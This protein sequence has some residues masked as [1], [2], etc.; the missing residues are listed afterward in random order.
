MKKVD[1]FLRITD[2]L[3]NEFFP[4]KTV[5]S[6]DKDKPFITQEIKSLIIKRDR[7]L[8]RSVNG[9]FRCY[10]SLVVNEIRKAKLSFYD[11]KVCPIRK[12]CPKAWWKQINK[13]IGKKSSKT[14]ILNPVT[15]SQM[16]DKST[17]N[18]INR[19]S[20]SLTKDY[21]KVNN[22]GWNCNA[23]EIYH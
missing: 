8:R 5:E 18:H 21:L 10:R 9:Q 14:T 13:L 23:Q 15:H 20:A 1:V 6:Y 22:N 4:E 17:A 2:G 16:D 3:I 19:F 12:Y 11:N 7:A